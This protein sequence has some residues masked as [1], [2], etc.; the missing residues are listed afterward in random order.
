[1]SKPADVLFKESNL[2]SALQNVKTSVILNEGNTKKVDV[3]IIVLN[4][5]QT[6]L[7][8]QDKQLKKLTA[9]VAASEAKTI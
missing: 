8:N 4:E 5:K 6:S 1:M 7:A 2:W 9:K 3:D